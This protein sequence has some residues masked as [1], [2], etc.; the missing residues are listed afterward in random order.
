MV[1]ARGAADARR[2]HRAMR[3]GA[4]DGTPDF[5]ARDSAWLK[6]GAFVDVDN[7][8]QM[9]PGLTKAQAYALLQAPHFGEAF[10]TCR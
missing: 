7:L 10:V 2:V 3:R 6:E 1:N 8:R 9:A 5:P 4:V